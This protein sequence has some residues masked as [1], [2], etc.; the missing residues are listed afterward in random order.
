MSAASPTGPDPAKSDHPPPGTPGPAP[1]PALRRSTSDRMLFGVAGG[2]ARHLGIDAVLVR[3]GFVLLALF[4]GSGVVLYLAG[5]VVI[6]ED[7][8]GQPVQH[9]PSLR[10]PGNALAVAGAVLVVLGGWAL[11]RQLVPGI[12]AVAG[13]LVLLAAGGLL[14]LAGRR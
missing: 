14:L 3:M 4:G 9:G 12:G 8:P 1:R 2:L 7:E 13:P 10:A 6:P 11:L 5:L